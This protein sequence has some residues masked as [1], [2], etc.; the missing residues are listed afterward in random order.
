MNSKNTALVVIDSVNG[1][2]HKNCEDAGKEITFSKIRKMIP[3][4]NNFI[5]QFRDKTGGKIIFTNITPWTKDYLPR[6]I[7][8]LYEDQIATYYGDGATPVVVHFV[9]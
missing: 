7:Q 9:R 6:N 8:E 3:R 4:L 1:C 5:R 2:C